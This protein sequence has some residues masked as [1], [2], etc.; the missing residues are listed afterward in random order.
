M[1]QNE[2]FLFCVAGVPLSGTTFASAAGLILMTSTVCSGAES[3]LVNC[4]FQSDTSRYNHSSDAGVK[5]FQR[6]GKLIL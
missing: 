5:C 6:D 3:K 4:Q 1:V 2:F